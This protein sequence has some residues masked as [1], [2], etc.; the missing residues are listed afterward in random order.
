MSVFETSRHGTL[1]IYLRRRNSG[2]VFARVRAQS[3]RLKIGAE[4]A[5]RRAG[6]RSQ[7][8]IGRWDK[9]T[10]AKAERCGWGGKSGEKV[11][12]ERG[13]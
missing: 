5:R 7:P 4:E 1:Q 6:W 12:G 3:L 10:E 8:T 11:V 13:D 9:E 2:G